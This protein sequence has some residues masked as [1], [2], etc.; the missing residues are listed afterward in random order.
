MTVPVVNSQCPQRAIQALVTEARRLL[1]P[2]GVLAIADNNPRRGCLFRLHLCLVAELFPD[3]FLRQKPL[4]FVS[5]TRRA[6]VVCAA[7]VS[8]HPKPAASTLC[9]DEVHRTVS[10]GRLPAII[11]VLLSLI[12]FST[13]HCICDGINVPTT[14]QVDGRVLQLRCGGV[15]ARGWLRQRADSGVRS[16]SS[17]SAR[18]GSMTGSRLCFGPHRT[19]SPGVLPLLVISRISSAQ[20]GSF[21]CVELVRTL[22]SCSRKRLGF[23][24]CC[25]KAPRSTH[26]SMM[27]KR[28]VHRRKRAGAP[29]LW[30]PWSE[31]TGIP[32]QRRTCMIR[33]T[34]ARGMPADQRG[35]KL[36]LVVV[37]AGQRCRGCRNDSDLE[38]FDVQARPA[39][40]YALQGQH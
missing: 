21:P 11:A 36:V 5:A 3:G 35:V 38:L 27:H 12:A 30:Q 33:G 2:R 23:L 15:H 9:S 13:E 4:R 20:V 39:Q 28:R 40:T 17:R 37:P 26:E 29:P 18:A 34:P 16:A 6:D 31:D 1:R 8:C 19:A 22:R 32:L 14:W 7:Q 24:E 25:L 10:F